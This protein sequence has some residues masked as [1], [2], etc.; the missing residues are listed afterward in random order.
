MAAVS[1]T[2]SCPAKGEKGRER[3]AGW[4][5]SAGRC[6]PPVPC[7]GSTS[8]SAPV[9]SGMAAPA[10]HH[11]RGQL[12]LPACTARRHAQAP[13]PCS[14][15]HAGSGRPNGAAAAPMCHGNGSLCHGAV[16]GQPRARR[17]RLPRGCP[18]PAIRGVAPRLSCTGLCSEVEPSHLRGPARPRR[19]AACP[20]S[21]A[22]RG[23]QALRR[24]YG[25]FSA[26][27][28]KIP[29]RHRP[30]DGCGQGV[31]V[32]VFVSRERLGIRDVN[33]AAVWHVNSSKS[34]CLSK[35]WELRCRRTWWASAPGS[36]TG[37]RLLEDLCHREQLPWET[38]AGSRV[39]P[40][41]GG[42]DS[43]VL[44]LG[45]APASPDS[46]MCCNFRVC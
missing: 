25:L 40:G 5:G 15:V 11:P 6:S 4:A 17:E 1:S 32:L 16:P 46:G 20:P 19:A 44:C 34:R 35:H 7:L 29:S 18:G 37:V 2:D 30:A 10:R 8:R 41:M 24:F 14:P 23:T 3:A 45:R 42:G 12:Q 36:P 27:V 31:R 33:H 22:H 26:S 43:P 28:N 13:R 38:P 39:W 21:G 9:P